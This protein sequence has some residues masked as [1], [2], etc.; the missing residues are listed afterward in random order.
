MYGACILFGE[1]ESKIFVE[2][3]SFSFFSEDNA[4]EGLQRWNTIEI[5]REYH[6]NPY[7]Y[8]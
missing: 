5:P 1:N 2:T 6:W 8:F 7:T 3:I 4:G